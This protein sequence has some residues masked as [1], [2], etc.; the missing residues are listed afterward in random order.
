MIYPFVKQDAKFDCGFAC[1]SMI[2]NYHQHLNIS[3]DELK[4]SNN[5]GDGQLSLLD[6]QRIL[7]KYKIKMNSY[8]VK[9]N[10][11]ITEVSFDKPI[12]CYCVNKEGMNHFVVAYAY[13]RK[14]ILIGDPAKEKL[15]WININ[16]FYKF[17]KNI[18]AIPEKQEKVNF[19]KNQIFIFLKNYKLFIICAV[20]LAVIIN[21]LLVLN[22]GFIKIYLDLLTR[23][24]VNQIFSI[25]FIFF[26]LILIK[27]FLKLAFQNIVIKFNLKIN[28]EMQIKF[29]KK[30]NRLK[31]INYQK[32]NNSQWIK[33]IEDINILARF[34]SVDFLNLLFTFIMMLFSLIILVTTNSILFYFTLFENL[35]TFLITYL[36]I[37]INKKYYD[38]YYKQSLSTQN[39][40][41][42]YV[43]SHNYRYNRNLNN[44]FF[45]NLI[46]EIESM[47]K[48]AYKL[49]YLRN[50]RIMYQNL[51]IQIF[52]LLIYYFSFSYILNLQM[53]LGDL[54]LCGALKSYLIDFNINVSGYI[55]DR[56]KYNLSFKRVEPILFYEDNEIKTIFNEKINTI[57]FKN[58]NFEYDG[59]PILKNLN[60][61]I[62]DNSLIRAP[63]GFGK[64]TLLK[65]I[66]Y[67]NNEYGGSLIIN[68]KYDL[69]NINNVSWVNKV[70][71]IEQSDYIFNGTILDNLINFNKENM[72]KLKNNFEIINII[73]S[74]KLNLEQNCF[75]NG[76]NL[77]KGQKQVIIFISALLEERD[78]YIFDESLSN[79]D[80]QLKIQLI[81]LL[82]KMKKNKLIIYASH[83]QELHKYF[84]NIIDL[85]KISNE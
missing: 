58:I 43:Y 59:Q 33:R 41:L 80:H 55:L 10:S 56:N 36:F 19:Q 35:A 29:W 12:I 71:L 28:K 63:S 67:G 54:M 84:S 70:L 82:F 75:N 2:I 34:I 30:V 5:F 27:S 1:V 9:V 25:C 11:L 44:L 57:D 21:I 48:S 50:S 69:N 17:F 26:F 78:L 4:F 66:N 62:S 32:N 79:V 31:P 61:R 3:V 16:I 49:T 14:K 81:K 68:D 42:E 85:E 51:T 8:E 40:F 23:H 22:K 60:F 47:N 45:I 73:E 39:Y 72:D 38:N 24:N 6:I 76:E 64:T 83:D 46:N 7:L 74:L 13:K 53:N 20:S 37:K 52:N 65:I 15:E 18:I 77:S